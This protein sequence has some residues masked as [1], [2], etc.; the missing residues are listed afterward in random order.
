MFVFT[1]EGPTVVVHGH[2]KGYGTGA[3]PN[4]A[5]CGRLGRVGGS[6]G[7]REIWAPSTF[8]NCTGVEDAGL[9][10]KSII[11]H[12]HSFFSSFIK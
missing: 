1:S 4:P 7:A 6:S 2:G 5:L 12:W 8:G 11:Y 3:P 9:Y 10:S